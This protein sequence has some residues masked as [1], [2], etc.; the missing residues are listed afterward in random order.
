MLRIDG[1]RGLTLVEVMVALTILSTVLI[2][3]GGLMFQAARHTRQSM[4]ASYRGAASSAAAAWA[5]GMPWDSLDTAVGC[6]ADT[7]GQFP[8]TRC[9]TV[10]DTAGLKRLTITI[11]STGNLSTRPDTVVVF[12]NKPRLRSPLNLY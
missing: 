11:V 5:E 12:R 6:K 7:M 3:L 10:A 2:A 1:E 8:F 4:A 9:T